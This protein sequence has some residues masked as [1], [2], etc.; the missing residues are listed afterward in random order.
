MGRVR[1]VSALF[2][3]AGVACGALVLMKF[4]RLEDA[5]RPRLM[6]VLRARLDVPPGTSLDDALHDS[7]SRRVEAVRVPAL[8]AQA[9]PNLVSP[10]EAELDPKAT[11]YLP[12]RA[13][14]FLTRDHLTPMTDDRA[15]ALLPPGS[16]RETFRVEGDNPVAP[17]DE[18]DVRVQGPDGAARTIARV[19]V[20]AVDDHVA[21]GE[22]QRERSTYRRMTFAAL[23]DVMAKIE[24]ARASGRRLRVRKPPLSIAKGT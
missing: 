13:G 24:D 2:V 17:G 12:V 22:P 23:P 19:L 4:R 16:V 8:L 20:F 1:L 9:L 7:K 15:R 11:I 10:Q 18:V 21:T 5:A 14:M 3:L 6:S